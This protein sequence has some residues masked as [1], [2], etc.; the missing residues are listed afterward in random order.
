MSNDQYGQRILPKLVDELAAATPN[1]VLGMIARSSDV[2][3]GFI[4]LSTT[5]LANAVNYTSWWIE[6]HIGKSSNF[7]TIA[8]LGATDFRFWAIE[9]AAIK[10]GYAA[11]LPSPRNSVENAVA[12]LESTKC[13]VIFYSA[14]MA[15]KV[16]TLKEA[17]PNIRTIEIPA[18]EVLTSTPAKAYPYTKTWE[19]AKND[20]VL[21]MHTSGST[22]TP[23][24]IYMNNDYIAILDAAHIIPAVPGHPL[25]GPSSWGAPGFRYYMGFPLFHLA[26]FA[27]TLAALFFE[28]IIVLGP[29][30]SPPNGRLVSDMLS[31]VDLDVLCA[32]PSLLEDLVKEYP[33][34]FL[35]QAKKID[36]FMYAG[37]PLS[38]EVGN[39]LT[40]HVRLGQLIGSTEASLFLNVQTDREDWQWFQWH[41]THSGIEL[42]K[43]EN[44]ELYEMVIRRQPGMERFQGIFK[45]MPEVQEWRTKDVYEKH[46]TKDLW[47]YRGRNDDVIVLSN[48]EKFN[49]VTMEGIINGHPK[50]TGALVVGARRPRCALL[51]E[52]HGV[53]NAQEFLD[54]VWPTVEEANKVSPGHAQI[55]RN[56]IMVIKEDKPFPRAAKGTIVRHAANKENAEEINALYG[57]SDEVTDP[58]V[59]LPQLEAEADMTSIRNFVRELVS[60][61]LD[62][63]SLS[64]DDDWFVRGLDSLQTIQLANNLKLVLKEHVS[65]SHIGPRII[66]ENPTVNK[67]ASALQCIL[68][69]EFSV[70]NNAANSEELRIANMKNTFNKL[71]S[72]LPKKVA[73]QALSDDEPL[74]VI[75]TGSTGSLGYYLLETM[76][77]DPKVQKVYCLNRSSNARDKFYSRIPEITDSLKSKD[78]K[79]Q[80]FQASFGAP[81]F[82]L[83]PSQWDQLLSEADVIIHN[84]WEV[85]FN[86]SLQTFEADHLRGLRTFIELSLLSPRHPSLNFVSSISAMGNWNSMYADQA[87]PE[88]IANDQEWSAALPM[89][90]GESKFVAEQMLHAATQAGISGNVL[91]LG[92]IAGPVKRGSI[93]VWNH[94]EWFPSLVK[95]TKNLGAAPKTLGSMNLI[96]WIPVDV[97]ADVIVEL[98]HNT[99]SRSTNNFNVFNLVNPKRVEFEHLVPTIIETFSTDRKQIEA[100]S[101]EEW[102]E[103]LGK[104][105][106]TKQEVL[107]IHPSLKIMDF[108][109]GLT[110]TEGEGLYSTDITKKTSKSMAELGPISSKDIG[111]WLEQWSY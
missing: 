111:T 27:C 15:S 2:S 6:D 91:R 11:L 79:V 4:E 61:I 93:G 10:T 63:P 71:I 23:K 50:V 68:S 86:H 43:V 22:G 90:Y 39:F 78:A 95:T 13:N 97:L 12:V 33:D 99:S 21:I 100:V 49:P 24:P 26:G 18:M 51:V 108:Y 16:K 38:P 73:S 42:E 31:Q 104:L 20:R 45:T 85:N 58:A 92:Q 74:T 30:S 75:L 88:R 81:N 41:P 106:S 56:M 89:G 29:P 48:G 60:M 69:P 101:P 25:A 28:G 57:A 54:S 36:L 80:F 14:E 47:L 62:V 98:V 102:L 8:Y 94:Q 66:Y 109:H 72:G 37:G 32:P 52:G 3:K 105:D 70:T 40:K 5:Q 82:G 96:D 9:L 59:K 110:S 53:E 67:L 46:P 7:E 44:S 76:L 103:R 19:E 87:I 55:G 1:R 64:D 84:A 65:G 107:E 77:R 35:A 83:L 17:R 34:E